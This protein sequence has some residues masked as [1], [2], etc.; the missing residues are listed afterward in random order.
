VIAL[1]AGLYYGTVAVVLGRVYRRKPSDALAIGGAIL[2]L[3]LILYY[4][5]L[6]AVSG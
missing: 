5:I 4:A 3:H 6:P 1:T 2:A